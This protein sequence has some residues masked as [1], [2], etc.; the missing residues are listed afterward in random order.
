MPARS[1]SWYSRSP[2]GPTTAAAEAHVDEDARNETES[3]CLDDVSATH[4]GEGLAG[5]AD[6][7]V[8]VADGGDGG[9]MTDLAMGALVDVLDGF[10]SLTGLP[11]WITIS[12]S[13]V[14]MRLSILPVLMLQLQK[15]AKIGQLFR[16]LPP[17]LPPPLSGRS[18]RDQYSLFQKK[19]RELGC[20]SFLWNLAYFSVQF[21]CFILW[22]SSIRSMCVNNHPGLDNGG[23]LWFHNLT[24]FSHGALGPVFPILV[25]GLHYLNMQI[26]FQTSQTKHYPG[27][28]ALLA[29]Y[30]KMYLDILSIPLFLIAYVVPQ[31]CLIYWTTNGLFTV[32]QQLYLRPG[33]IRKM[34]GLPDIGA[35]AGN[36][37]FRSPLEG[38]EMIQRW[39]RGE[40]RMQS[41]LGSS[42]NGTTSEN[43]TPKFM[44]ESSTLMEGDVSEASTPEDLLEQAL[45]HLENGCQ[46]QAIPLIRTAIEKNPD[47]STSLIAMA[48]TFYSKML[49]SEASLC[50]EHAIPQMKEQ[51]PLIVLA[52]FGAGLSCRKQGDNEA[53]IEHLQRLAEL[54]E[55]ELM[56]NKACY[57][58]GIIVLGSI[59]SNEGRKSEAAKYLR[60]A[61]AYDPAA[62]RLLKECEE[63]V[64]DQPKSAEH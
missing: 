32:A 23:V 42:D 56:M 60:L 2:S 30:Y 6:A 11:W 17:P 5:A 46:D 19:R 24:E 33:V 41:R 10:H 61:L 8:V 21:P 55:P 58:R 13:T 48:Q 1:F 22:I 36:T 37:A 34:F 51:D 25:A 14:A 15:T 49:F 47:L 7:A 16:Q 53:A 4:Y 52:H 45:Q 26:S 28:L 43:M 9:G 20:P 18:F 27:V 40:F 29:K 50:Y 63:A 35:R 44:F 62:E 57:F 54:K 38:Q 64:E 12:F 59:L 31:G 3:V 39:P